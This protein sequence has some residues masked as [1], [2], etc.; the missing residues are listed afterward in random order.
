[1]ACTSRE[2]PEVGGTISVDR[3]WVSETNMRSEQPFG[4]SEEDQALIEHFR[5]TSVVQPFKAR[6]EEDGFGVVVGRRRFLAMK[7]AGYKE[8]TV[9][10][11]VWVQEMTDDEAM[12]ASLKENLE[13]FHQTP[14]SITRAEAINAYLSRMP[15]GGIRK[16]AATW[17]ISASTLSEYLKILDLNK[18]MRETVRKGFVTFRD[19][20]AV[21]RL[22]LGDA[23]QD[24]LAELATENRDAFKGE[25]GRLMAGRG[26]RGIPRGVYQVDR[27]VWDKR[28]RK[29]MGYYE[30]LS[31]AAEAKGVKVP[32]LIKDFVMRH[33]DEIEKEIA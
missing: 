26:K 15:S 12:D 31:R 13:E 25:L 3:F 11:H 19:A 28:S 24:R 29:E 9:G 16:L 17:N 18:R 14:D 27:V 1:M 8:F 10:V 4:E 23:A 32:E 2:L 21:V 22:G 33:I 6:P 30:I 5:R 20:L 7:E